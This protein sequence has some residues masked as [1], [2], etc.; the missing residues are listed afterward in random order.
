[1][2]RAALLRSPSFLGHDT[3][4]HPEN[5]GRI[6]AIDRELAA[7]DALRDRPAVP[8]G[9]ISIEEAAK[10]HAPRYLAALERVTALGGGWL[11]ADTFCGSDSLAVARLA[12][13]ASVAAVN[14]VLDE[15]IGRA[16]VLGRPPGHHATAARGMGF[17]LLNS[18]AIAANHALDR[19][20]ERVAIVDWDVHHGNGTQEIFYENPNVLY[21]SSHRYGRFYPGTGAANERGVGA[22][23]GFTVNVPLNA[24]AGDEV[25][26]RVY[27]ETIFPRVER[28][29]PQ[30]LLISAGFDAHRDDPLGGLAM[31]ERG[32]HRLASM[33][34]EVAER[35]AGGRVV[36]ILEGGYDPAALGRSVAATLAAL[37][38][39]PIPLV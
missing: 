12:A 31:T 34:V 20:L 13:G 25:V 37:D 10:T 5:P 15:S 17:C 9:L 7:R 11:D 24:G 30:L 35:L 36:T 29:E 6:R 28:F 8:F 26:E 27:R 18:I 1:V 23:E 3:G 2:T 19:G 16:F 4:D 22:G 39:E 14:A 21:C 38:G 33:A 32:F